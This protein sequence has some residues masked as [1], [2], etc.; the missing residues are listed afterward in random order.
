MMKRFEMI[1]PK[2]PLE[3]IKKDKNWSS[4]FNSLGRILDQEMENLYAS[5][6]I[7]FMI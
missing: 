5:K 1:N 6:F 2:H 3:I 4:M 7:Y